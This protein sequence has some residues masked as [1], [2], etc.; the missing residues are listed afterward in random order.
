ML[1][2]LG[3]SLSPLLSRTAARLPS[4]PDRRLCFCW[5]ENS[6]NDQDRRAG[7]SEF[8]RREDRL[9]RV[10]L[11][12]IS[13]R[14]RKK[15]RSLCYIRLSFRS[16][17]HHVKTNHVVVRVGNIVNEL[18]KN[19]WRVLMCTNVCIIPAAWIAFATRGDNN[20][21]NSEVRGEL[22]HSATETHLQIPWK[23]DTI[24]PSPASLFAGAP[25]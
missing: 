8:I 24:P 16:S 10:V 20:N 7:R 15:E 23:I 25:N 9:F 19:D 4:R 3:F 11:A 14:E 18:I 5:R 13:S 22:F 2:L 6:R 12:A 21:D 1:S 17:D